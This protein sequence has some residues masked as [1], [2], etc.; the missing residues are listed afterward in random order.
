MGGALGAPPISRWC[1]PTGRL[2]LDAYSS[3]EWLSASVRLPPARVEELTRRAN[4]NS[5]HGLRAHVSACHHT[6]R[7]SCMAVCAGKHRYRNRT[8]HVGAR[9]RQRATVV[10]TGTGRGTQTRS[11]GTYRL[12][13]PV[14]RYELR[15]RAVGYASGRDSV[16]V[17]AGGTNTANF[18]VEKASRHSK[19][20]RRWNA[21]RSAHRDRCTGSHRHSLR[22]ESK[23]PVVLR[24]HR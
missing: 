22:G 21:W 5:D 12:T 8:C 6:R 3:G 11:D 13:L 4:A 19:P 20:S 14:G 17:V 24:W 10:A 18:A 16:T 23:P 2:S 1:T 7:I 9:S 15:A